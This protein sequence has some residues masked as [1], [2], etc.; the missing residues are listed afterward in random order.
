M[1]A[2]CESY[3]QKTFKTLMQTMSR[4]GTVQQLDLREGDAPY[5]PILLTLLDNE[6]TFAIQGDANSEGIIEDIKDN[7]IDGIILATGSKQTSVEQADFILVT[8]GTN[9]ADKAKRGDLRYP[10]KGATIIYQV[11]SL[12][13]S[14]LPIRLKG[15]GIPGERVLTV[16]GFCQ[17]EIVN[18]KAANQDFP[19]GVDLILVDS[20]ARVSCIPR[21]TRTEVV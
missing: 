7:I 15:P 17:E 19:M 12:N 5:M 20:E 21:T 13:G 8:D 11:N 2:K 18:V 3:T 1:I 4:P 14:D 10:D 16:D 6:V 9:V